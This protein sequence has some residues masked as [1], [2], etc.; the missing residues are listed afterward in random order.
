MHHMPVAPQNFEYL[1]A[2]REAAGEQV[3]S[4]QIDPDVSNDAK[5]IA[6]AITN[7]GLEVATSILVGTNELLDV[8]DRPS[9]P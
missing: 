7:A 1:N 6:A 8:L 3:A 4:L 9:R 5:L 2:R